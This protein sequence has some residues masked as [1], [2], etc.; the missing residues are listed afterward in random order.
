MPKYK[1]VCKACN[2]QH[3]FADKPVIDGLSAKCSSCGLERIAVEPMSE[4]VFSQ[5]D[6]DLFITNKGSG[7]SVHHGFILMVEDMKGKSPDQ[8]KDVFIDR[9][10][11]T[12]ATII[13]KPENINAM[14]NGGR[15]Q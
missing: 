1:I 5:M 4:E 13:D 2:T 9:V 7:Q 11:R 15:T 12:L 3:G 14:L 8:I 6:F 10:A